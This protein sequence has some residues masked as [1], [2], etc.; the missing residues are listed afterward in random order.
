MLTIGDGIAILSACA[1]I[2]TALIKLVGC[3]EP[4]AVIKNGNTNANGSVKLVS[5]E[6][7]D[8][9]FNRI[10][11]AIGDLKNDVA[12]VYDKIDNIKTKGGGGAY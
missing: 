2:I 3:K 9:R 7:C 8:E 10:L 12:G 6:V 11:A 5:K 1:V 4:V